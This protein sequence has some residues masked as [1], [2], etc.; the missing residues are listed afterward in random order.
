MVLRYLSFRLL[1]DSLEIFF[2]SDS[3]FRYDP[4]LDSCI[5][6]A[7][8]QEPRGDFVAVRFEDSIFVFGGRNRSGAMKNCEKYNLATNEW[9]YIAALPEV[10][11][12]EMIKLKKTVATMSM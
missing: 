5:E 10:I 7:S 6:V 12:V 3:V 9:T 11:S 4:R 8:M 1:L 2:G